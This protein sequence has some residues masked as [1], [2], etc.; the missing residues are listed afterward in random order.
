MFW[1]QH[2][3]V[4]HRDHL[5]QAIY[6]WSYYGIQ[7][8]IMP[9]WCWKVWKFSRIWETRTTCTYTVCSTRKVT[10]RAQPTVAHALYIL[11]TGKEEWNLG[12]YKGMQMLRAGDIFIHDDE[13]PVRIQ[14]GV[15]K[16]CVP[17]Q[18]YC[19]I[20]SRLTNHGI[21]FIWDPDIALPLYNQLHIILGI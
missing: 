21:N 14:F 10:E 9:E 13:L 19:R 1:Q 7:E 4:V 17:Q 3:Q 5:G 2:H 18:G 12:L 15:P 11:E 6:S 16:C 20:P 8:T